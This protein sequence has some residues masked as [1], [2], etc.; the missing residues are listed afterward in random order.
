M[1]NTLPRSETINLR[2]TAEEK[3][4][5]DTA[6]RMVGKSR[7]EFMLEAARLAAESTILE[8]P[9][10]VLDAAEF[11]ELQQRLDAPPEP[12]EALKRLMRGG[13]SSENG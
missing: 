10:A 13:V 1:S 8:R 4:M 9:I 12:A 5:I 3:S 11:A 2:T 7:T 6:A